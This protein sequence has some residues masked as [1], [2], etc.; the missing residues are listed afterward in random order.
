M[1]APVLSVTMYFDPSCAW[2]WRAS[3]WLAEMTGK[4]NVPVQWRA[5]DLRYGIALADLPE[6]QQGYASAA[7]PFLR[8]VEAAHRDG[9]AELAGQVYARYGWATH[10]DTRPHHPDLVREIV[11]E[12]APKYTGALDDTTLDELTATAHAEALDF[13]GQDEASPVTVIRTAAGERGFFGPVL[14]PR[15]VGEQADRVWDLVVSAATLPEFFELTAR[16]S[17]RRPKRGPLTDHSQSVLGH[18]Q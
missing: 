3:R 1:T 13:A 11:A 4:R 7:R 18:L 2:G 14:G 8:F 6:S 15:P 16:R 5:S 10:E 9:A 12:Y 17:W